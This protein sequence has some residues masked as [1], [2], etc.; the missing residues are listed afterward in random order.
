MNLEGQAPQHADDLP[1]VWKQI[2]DK[3]QIGEQLGLRWYAAGKG[4]RRLN[5]FG[6]D[7]EQQHKGDRKDTKG[8]D[9]KDSSNVEVGR[10]GI[11][12]FL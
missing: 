11:T 9:S 2:L 3:E 10:S 12:I 7:A 5:S 1:G 4:E 8:I 6:R